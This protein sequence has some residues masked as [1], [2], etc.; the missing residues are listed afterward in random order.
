MADDWAPAGWYPAD[1][2]VQRLSARDELKAVQQQ[3]PQ[4]AAEL[5]EAAGDSV[6]RRFVKLTVPD[7][8]WYLEPDKELGLEV[9]SEDDPGRWWRRRPE[10]LPW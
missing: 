3:L 8:A 10:P 9:P 1:L 2:Y 4:Q 5:L 6:D 7:P